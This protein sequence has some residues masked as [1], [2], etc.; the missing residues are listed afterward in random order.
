MDSISNYTTTFKINSGSYSRIQYAVIVFKN[1]YEIHGACKQYKDSS[2]EHCNREINALLALKHSNIIEIY[3][4]DNNIDGQFLLMEIADAALTYIVRNKLLNDNLIH[5]FIVDLINGMN[6]IHKSGFIHGDLSV[7]NILI[8]NNRLKICDFGAASLITN[9]NDD[10]NFK[11]RPLCC[12]E[13]SRSVE[14][15][16]WAYDKE[17]DNN[18]DTDIFP[19]LPILN[20][21]K[22]D[23]WSI[24]CIIYYIISRCHFVTSKHSQELLNLY[25]NKLGDPTTFDDICCMPGYLKFIKNYQPDKSTNNMKNIFDSFL[26]FPKEKL[27]VEKLFVFDTQKRITTDELIQIYI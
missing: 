8:K 17:C 5:T 10:N 4:Y 9:V 14:V 13:Y 19:D 25:F 3:G 15:T 12:H 6:Y 11:W 20:G 23:M 2:E 27:L 18:F 21:I 16:L 1:N 7:W 22:N 26:F 24:G